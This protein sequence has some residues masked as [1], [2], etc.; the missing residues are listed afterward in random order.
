ME[1]A[2]ALN[3]QHQPVE[4]QDE[5]PVA[6]EVEVED[7]RAPSATHQEEQWVD[8][9]VHQLAHKSRAGMYV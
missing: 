7:P 6:E 9:W 1:V 4:H 3:V 5:P 8:Q 2:A